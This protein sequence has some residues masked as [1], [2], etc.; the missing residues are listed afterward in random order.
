MASVRLYQ[1]RDSLDGVARD[2]AKSADPNS[3]W[4]AIQLDAD[5]LAFHL[6]AGNYLGSPTHIYSH[7]L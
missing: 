3:I 5:A 4:L 6:P 2:V 7:R 1:S